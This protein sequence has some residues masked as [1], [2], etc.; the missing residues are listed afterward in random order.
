[1]SKNIAVF[2]GSFDPFTNGHLDIVKRTSKLFDELYILIAV[3]SAKSKP[4][5][6]GPEKLEM[7]YSTVKYL[8]NVYADY[9]SLSTVGYCRKMDANFIIR[10]VRCATDFESEY[11]LSLI[12]E[13]LCSSVQTIFI[14]STLNMQIVSS[15]L[16]R[17]LK[18]INQ[19][20]S[21]FVPGPIWD[22]LQ[23]KS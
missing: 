2:P 3:N 10:G 5:F 18:K 14:P 21:R 13:N 11:T 4:L 20:Y 12:N 8:G 15:S 17:E 23:E 1:M 9:N 22:A 19:D 16:V 6:T 7:I